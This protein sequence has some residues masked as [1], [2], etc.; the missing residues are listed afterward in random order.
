MKKQTLMDLH[1]MMVCG[2][3][4]ICCCSASAQTF[5]L[6]GYGGYLFQ[7]GINAFN[8]NSSYCKGKVDGG[9]Q[10]GLGAE[11]MLHPNLGL[12]LLYMREDTRA[13]LQYYD[14]GIKE[15]EFDVAINYILLSGNAY[16]RPGKKVDPYV[17]LLVGTALLEVNN[18]DNGEGD[19]GAKLAWGLKGGVAYAVSDQFGLLAQASFLS[20]FKAIGGSLFLGES[21]SADARTG[22]LQFGFQVGVSYQFR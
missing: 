1:T 15:P 5:R 11:Y 2:L 3:F 6:N 7:D 9:M 8:S 16:L 14:N 20:A 19:H 22:L 13:P 21:S 12:E 17:S 4:T 10:W 18:P